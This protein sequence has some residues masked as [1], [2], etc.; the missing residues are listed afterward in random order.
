MRELFR[1]DA[2]RWLVPG[3]IG[4]PSEVTA[5]RAAILLYRHMGLRAVLALRIG[6]WFKSRGIP[7]APS[8]MQRLIYRR[9]GLDIVVGAPIGGGLYIAH[10]IGTTLA[11][12]R[13]GENCSVI[14]AV[15]V[16]LRNEH[17]FPVIGDRVFLGAGARVLGGLVVGDDARIGANAVVIA[18]VAPDTSV[19]GIPAQPL[20]TSRPVAAVVPGQSG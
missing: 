15:T 20:G 7:L 2:A 1:S 6:R 5:A 8:F 14:A 17:A 13:M 3:E 18:D 19:G 9:Y 16:G 10:P 4:D 12:A 11:P